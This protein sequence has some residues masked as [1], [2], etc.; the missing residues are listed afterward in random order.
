M[1]QQKK[2]NAARKI[3]PRLSPPAARLLRS[4]R[5]AHL[6]TADAS[7]KPHVIPICFAVAG[8]ELYTPLDAKPKRVA[9]LSLKRVRNIIA[10]PEVA[11]VVDTYD[12]DWRRL[13]YVLLHGRARIVTRGKL[14]D[15]AVRLL[16]IKYMQYRKMPLLYHPVV[17]IRWDRATVWSAISA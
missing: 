16:K 5:V 14:H 4:A 6:A 13:A 10:N 15:K 7:G 3:F 1:Q 11:V 8:R 2:R 17:V 12:E 9:A